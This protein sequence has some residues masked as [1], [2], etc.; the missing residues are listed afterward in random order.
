MFMRQIAQLAHGCLAVG[1]LVSAA[2]AEPL[3]Y[4]GLIGSLNNY[5]QHGEM[6]FVHATALDGNPTEG[7]FGA[8]FDSRVTVNSITIDQ[9]ID[10]GRHR[11][12]DL[13]IYTSP[14]TYSSVQLADS[15][16]PQTVTL[17]G[18]GLTSDYFFIT[19]ES[20]YD[21]GAVDNNPGLHGLSFD[22][23]TGAART[24]LNALL[25][26]TAVG[27]FEPE[28][29]FTDVITNGLNVSTTGGPVDYLFFEHADA[30]ERSITVNYGSPQTVASVGLAFEGQIIHSLNARPVPKF[31]TIS[32]S[33][34]NQRQVEI[35][36]HTA[37]YGQYPLS[38]PLTNTTSLTITLPV[39]VENWPCEV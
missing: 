33:N 24:N 27:Q 5:N 13:R 32:D 6:G 4:R 16:G 20:L 29:Y 38:S 12:K 7:N 19:V 36:P 25:P 35:E 17:P 3:V 28:N 8:I 14:Y 1:V 39:G 15:Q 30:T 10:A 22:G 21:A 37:Q 18:A 23:T 31:V 26:P 11:M 9:R 2:Q 34:G